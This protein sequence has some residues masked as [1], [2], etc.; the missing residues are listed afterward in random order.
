MLQRI[1]ARASLVLNKPV[2]KPASLCV[3]SLLLAY[4]C[5]IGYK[6][7]SEDGVCHEDYPG[8]SDQSA[9]PVHLVALGIL[10]MFEPLSPF[11]AEDKSPLGTGTYSRAAQLCK[12]VAAYRGVPLFTRSR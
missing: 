4:V 6:R 10:G 3:N 5:D 11:S 8:A 2:F 1:V 9:S 12:I 7:S